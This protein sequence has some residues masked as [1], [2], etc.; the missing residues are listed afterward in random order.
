MTNIESDGPS[1]PVLSSITVFRSLKHSQLLKMQRQFRKKTFEDGSVLLL[2]GDTPTSQEDALFV[3]ASGSV[4]VFKHSV[5]SD[6]E[7]V[8][9]QVAQLGSGKAVGELAL[10]GGAQ[11]KR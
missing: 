10:M 1:I 8:E 9:S 6:G 4:A 7:E 3:I 5:L 11:G 2:E